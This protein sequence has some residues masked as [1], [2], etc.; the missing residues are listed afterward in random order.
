M[1]VVRQP[2]SKINEIRCENHPVKGK[3]EAIRLK[4][5]LLGQWHCVKEMLLPEFAFLSI[6]TRELAAER[7][8][9]NL[10]IDSVQVLY[11]MYLAQWL[12]I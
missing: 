8:E 9:N 11:I 6:C 1:K 4:E 12:V 2:N 10:F 5:G 7:A 3:L